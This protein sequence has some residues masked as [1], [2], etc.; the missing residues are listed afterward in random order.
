MTTHAILGAVAHSD[1]PPLSGLSIAEL[2]DLIGQ[3]A[4]VKDRVRE[5]DAQLQREL[6][7]RFA[8]R[9]ASL[10]QQ[11]GKSTGT[12]RFDEDGYAVIADLPKRVEW[13]QA[14][15]AQLARQIIA[16]GEDPAEYVE[17]TY[18][19]SETKY[20]AWPEAIRTAFLPARTVK[21][22]RPAFRLALIETNP[23]AEEVL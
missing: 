14:R 7:T 3:V 9:A 13:D 19:V 1:L 5:W 15:L 6:S 17:V 12:V 18:R 20:N 22:G 16:N 8:A 4:A 11:A 10:R 2:D 21:T 23:A